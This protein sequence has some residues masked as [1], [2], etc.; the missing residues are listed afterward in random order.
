MFLKD[1]SRVNVQQYVTN[2]MSLR[3]ELGN[4]RGRIDSEQL[5]PNGT[6]IDATDNPYEYGSDF[7]DDATDPD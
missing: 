2:L 3:E 6:I 1:A 4:I 7:I 5:R